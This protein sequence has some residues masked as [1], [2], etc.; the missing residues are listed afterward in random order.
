MSPHEATV[1]HSEMFDDKRHDHDDSEICC[2]GCG[3]E[4]TLT[5][6][7]ILKENKKLIYFLYLD[8]IIC[9]GCL[10]QEITKKTGEARLKVIDYGAAYYLNFEGGGMNIEDEP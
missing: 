3:L 4:Y 8:F 1:I 6:Y 10:F 2:D 7:R 5:D 9:H